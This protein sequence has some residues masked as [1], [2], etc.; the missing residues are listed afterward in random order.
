VLDL[1]CGELVTLADGSDMG[2]F[3]RD[4]EAEDMAGTLTADERAALVR[5]EAAVEAGVSVTATVIEAGKALA[6]IRNRQLFRDS[7]GSW[8]EYIHAR[9]KITPRRCNQLIAFAGV[10]STLDEI[11]EKTGT[12]VPE[13]SEKAARP[14]VG[15]AQET[16]AEIVA[17]AAQAPE[18]VTAK[19]IR[20]AAS[21]RRKAK[22]VKVPRPVRLK[23][24]GGIVVVE[25]NAKGVKAGITV[26]AALEAA[27]DS[28]RRQAEAA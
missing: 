12:R 15:L 16:V 1:A 7:A 18:G 14:L 3:T 24:P 20:K 22:A 8:D 25:I 13:I 6:E 19:T 28:V 23:V 21:K 10:K 2:W 4:T 11:S 17:E 5:L 9:F 27:I 26:E